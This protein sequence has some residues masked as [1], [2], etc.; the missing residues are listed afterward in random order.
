MPSLPTTVWENEFQA[1]A[2]GGPLGFPEQRH[3][4]WADREQKTNP[5][6]ELHTDDSS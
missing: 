5:R 6:P 2:L 4:H 1:G 3:P